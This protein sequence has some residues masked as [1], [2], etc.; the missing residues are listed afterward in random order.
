MVMMMVFMMVNNHLVGGWATYPS[1]NKSG[2]QVSW[3]DIPFP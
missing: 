3:D 1:E 2:V